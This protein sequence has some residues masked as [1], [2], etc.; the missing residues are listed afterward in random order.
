MKMR[1]GSDGWKLRASG[2]EDAIA[3]AA[4]LALRQ[5]LVVGSDVAAE[6]PAIA[7]FAAAVGIEADIGPAAANEPALLGARQTLNGV[8][9]YALHQLPAVLSA[10]RDAAERA[11]YH[12]DEP[13]ESPSPKRMDGT[14][15]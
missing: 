10:S 1:Y 6:G 8:E 14:H 4:V 11:E 5:S 9:V 3:P 7:E 12:A 2:A 13:V 15:P